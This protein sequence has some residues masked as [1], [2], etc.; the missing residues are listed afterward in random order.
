M[1]Y[2]FPLLLLISGLLSAQVTTFSAGFDD[3]PLGAPPV[4]ALGG[5]SQPSG[6]FGQS[7]SL[8]VVPVSGN[9]GTT[10]AA[11]NAVRV[12]VPV[13]DTYRLI[14]FDGE[15]I[16]GL[17]TSGSIRV[18]FDMLVEGDGN[19]G[20]AFFRSYDEEAE[21]FADLGFA[22]DGSGV[23][24]GTLDYDPATGA[25]LGWPRADF[26]DDNTWHRYEAVIDLDENTIRLFLDGVDTG[27]TGGIN[28]SDGQAY[29]GTWMN[30]GGAFVGSCLVDNFRVEVPETGGL[31]DAPQGFLDLLNNVPDYGGTV[32]R[33]PGG[34]FRTPGLDWETYVGAR[35][36]YAPVYDGIATYRFEFDNDIMD[37]ADARLFATGT[38]PLEYNRTYEVSALIRTDFPRPTWEI[39]VGVNGRT[40]SG[41]SGFG[42]RY[43]GTPAITSGPD[44]WERW[45]WRF[46]PHWDDRF[47]RAEVALT[48]HEYGPGFDDNVSFEI[49]DLAFVEL[50]AAPLTAFAPGTGVTFPGGAGA[51]D[52]Q[53]EEVGG[54]A[55]AISVKNSAATFDFDVSEGTLTVTQRIGHP[56][57]LTR[58]TNLP[59]TG[60]SVQSQND[61][62][63]ILV[64]NDVTIGVQADGTAV[65]SPH[66]QMDVG[67]T[68]LIGGDF[69]RME[70]GDL[71][72]SDDWGGFTANIHVPRGTGRRA[73]LSAP[74][75]LAF[76]GLDPYDQD[77]GGAEEPGW[78]A[79]ARV[80]A[81]ERLFV[82]AFPS[83]P[84]DWGRSF[85]Q[86]WDIG[87]FGND[88]DYYDTPDYVTDWILWNFNQRG[89][90]MSQGTRYEIRTDIDA[91]D[92]FNAVSANGDNWIAYFSQWFYYSRDAEEWTNEIARWQSEYG[93]GG[94]YSDGLAQDD[95]LSAYESMRRLRG[96]VFPSGT[97]IIHDSY[98]QSGVPASSFR[99]FIYTYAT[100]TYMGENAIS[101]AGPEWN[102]ARY[103]MGQY[104]KANCFGVTK[105]DG[106]SS[107][108]SVE[109]Y[110]VALV[111]GGRG[112][113]DVS[114]YDSQYMPILRQLETLWETYGDDPF[115]FDRYYHPD[116]QRLTG[117][118]IGR[119]GMP[120]FEVSDDNFV[121]TATNRTAGSSI[122]Y[123]TDGSDPTESDPEVTGPITVT[124]PTNF[125]MRS[126]RDDLD[127]SWIAEISV[128]GA[129]LPVEWAAVSARWS[130]DCRSVKLEWQTAT[131]ESVAAFYV[132][133]STATGW[134]RIGSPVPGGI[135]NYQLLDEG[136]ER[137]YDPSYRIV[138]IDLDGSQNHS[139]IFRPRGAQCGR[140]TAPI[141]LFPNPAGNVLF[142]SY[143][144][145]NS[146]AYRVIDQTGR[147]VSSGQ[148]N[149]RIDTG[150]LVGGVYQLELDEGQGSRSYHRF[151]K[152]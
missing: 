15:S 19:E 98:P 58:L 105:G 27:V 110:L 129:A 108:Q 46:V 50:P 67:V 127:E 66:G 78:T 146:L 8:T 33:L 26:I 142:L 118:E 79:T 44:G 21:S 151:V 149:G 6:L 119:A 97:I 72:S 40:V 152:Q 5:G 9:T 1:K 13:A 69:N 59:L 24:T 23:S 73:N 94:M 93:M 10:A 74:A 115:F 36:V 34:D 38:F 114:D 39:S 76:V 54:A 96:D 18:G 49:A 22:F 135:F 100:S 35:L 147:V 121:L 95:W 60:L 150:R 83:R 70:R 80:T 89:W 32:L 102:W 120:I 4:V 62:V 132:E 45:T 85:E 139:P 47:T 136:I 52:M 57:P 104:N 14:D 75:G 101:G 77:T 91:Q 43:G 145:A 17:V 3:D 53:L 130:D 61:D 16:S 116:A 128:G 90:A 37:E 106:W 124:Q 141:T 88:L 28:R 56:R 99:P 140:G 144:G 107:G 125:R 138:Q 131:E 112:R 25:Y 31:P 20:F 143:D 30:W 71:L 64:G 111:W 2:L 29:R 48:F 134:E 41:E 12:S 42:L 65:I 55:G 148:T 109:K 123:T 86:Q 126:Y 133:R 82:S 103:V 63:A 84:Y 51:L 137:G 92:H 113:P 87:D 68:S 7:S 81:G 117:Y 122:H 11:G